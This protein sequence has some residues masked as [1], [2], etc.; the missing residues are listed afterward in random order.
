MIIYKKDIIKLFIVVI[1]IIGL[2]LALSKI[3]KT[4]MKS[5][6]IGGFTHKNYKAN[7]EVEPIKPVLGLNYELNEERFQRPSKQPALD[8]KYNIKSSTDFG[9]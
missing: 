2:I 3:S 1:V 7:E 4:S 5:F 8:L 6:H 9:R